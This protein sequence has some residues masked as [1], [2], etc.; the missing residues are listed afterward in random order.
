MFS[1]KAHCATNIVS[2]IAAMLRPT[3]TLAIGVSSIA[4]LWPSARERDAQPSANPPARIQRHT[5]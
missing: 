3:A 5:R 1:N 4:I 2:A